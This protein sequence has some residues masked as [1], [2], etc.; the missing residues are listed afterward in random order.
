MGEKNE[1]KRKFRR[2]EKILGIGFRE[3]RENL[4]EKRKFETEEKI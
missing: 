2:E 3:R 4:G 1:E